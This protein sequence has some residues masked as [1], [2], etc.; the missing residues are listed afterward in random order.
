MHTIPETA[1]RMARKD[2]AAM[3]L[4]SEFL[5]DNLY[6]LFLRRV[7]ASFDEFFAKRRDEYLE[8]ACEDVADEVQA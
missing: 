1:E 6:A 5:P 2:Y 4:G 3:M 8:K 7:G